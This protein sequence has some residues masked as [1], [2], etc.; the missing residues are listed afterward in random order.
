M[1][2]SEVERLGRSV[3]YPFYSIFKAVQPFPDRPGLSIQLRKDR[4]A[5]TRQSGIYV[6]HHPDWGY[7]YVGIAAADNFTERW[8]KHIQKLLDNCSSAK[9]MA[10]WQAFAQKF[11]SA[12]YGIDDL[13]DITLRFY[14]RPNTGSPTFK[15][16]LADLE[17]RIVAT[18]NPACNKEY[19]PNRPS[20]TR[21]P[22]QRPLKESSGYSLA[23]S[24]TH[25]L[26][27]SKVWLLS[28]LAK[29]SPTTGTVYILGSWYGNLSL[30][31]NLLPLIRYTNIINVEKNKT[32]LDQSRRMLDH[33][34]VDNVE[35]M[36]KDANDLDYR[37]LGN[38]GIVINTSLT[39]MDGTDWFRHIPDGTLVVMQARDRDPGYQFD[40]AQDILRKFP[41]EQV[42][43][44]GTKEL[45]D[46]ETRYTR[47][48]II[49]RK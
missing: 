27:T 3:R 5:E 4:P 46:P 35:F 14:P 6:W 42:L 13:K 33:I 36:H 41:L 1:R 26:T 23:G 18:I 7:F 9:Q 38:A 28:E 31:M 20:A 43:Y 45:Q 30:Y 19:D 39:D 16:E 12:G 25:D 17:T 29:I 37:Q 11:A 22:V 32:M 48:M 15:Q 49:G 34:G 24:F 47:F 2:L 44:A 8:N 40:S 21:F 10:N